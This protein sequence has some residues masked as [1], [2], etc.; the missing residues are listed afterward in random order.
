MSDPG[1]SIV[2]DTS[3][4]F[5]ARPGGYG[6]RAYGN[7]APSGPL[8]RW[9]LV[10]PDGRVTVYAGKVEYGQN[11]R[12]GL[13]VEVADELRVPLSSV[14][15]ILGDTD[16]TPW[17]MGTFGSQ[18]TARAGLQL[19]HAAATARETLIEMAA[20]RLDLPGEDLII[21]DGRI[22]SSAD[23]GRA[24]SY[25]DLL[26]GETLECPIDYD[27]PL[28]S[29]SGFTVMGSDVGRID[30]EARV[31]GRAVYSQDVIRP[32]MLFAGVLRA[33]K[34]GAQLID[35]DTSAAERMP[36]VERVVREGDLI[37]VLAEDDESAER[38]LSAVQS[39]WE[40][41]AEGSTIDVPRILAKTRR[42][43]VAVQEAG[44]VAGA[45][46]AAERV[47]EAT[48]YAP[49]ITPLPM[50]PRATVAEW[51][52]DRL[53]VW[54]GTQRPFGLR[55]E[56]SGLFRIP[57]TDVHVISMEI[58][59]GFGTKSWYPVAAEAAK[60]ARIA[61]RP[62]RVAY[63]RQEDAT[64][65]TYRP[66]ALIEI[67]S[68]FRSDGT[69]TAWQCDA[70]HAGP[71]AN[72]A[73]REAKTPYA[74]ENVAVNV[75][76]ANTLVRVGSYRTLGA[77]ANNFARE[78]HMDEIAAQLDIDPFEVR[79]RNLEEPR[80]R[81][82]L[83][84][85]ATHFGWTDKRPGIGLAVGEDVG[86]YVATCAEVTVTGRDIRVRR[87]VTA[88]DCGLTV[89]PEG[90]RN[91]VEGATVMGLGGALYEAA[92]LAGGV[93]LNTSLSR[94]Q[95]PR[96][97]DTPE[98]EV[99]LLGDPADPSTGAGEPGLVTIAPVLANAVFNATGQRIRELPLKRQ[100]R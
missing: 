78:S 61:G 84:A 32:G 76:C 87:V 72:I 26:T 38:A 30:A 4:G 14:E 36:G 52:G 62:V 55:T 99:L 9:L 48:Y 3:P 70:V 93:I 67:R 27:A 65:G 11:I 20:R 71:I 64:E 75:Y 25:S 60:L 80:Y 10:R 68:A 91:Q 74:I 18:S 100:L 13:A 82:V 63:T 17:D 45:F 47:L 94:Y 35:A 2:G 37:A 56:L 33:P 41:G 85:A 89:N 90:V 83:K 8:V 98:I 66:A 15:V 96:I 69:V 54:A 6:A 21:G 53:T 29:P 7:T 57:E 1:L 88:I 24:F 42:D 19:R 79:M 86:T 28:T 22:A 73:Q 46:R 40:G 58:G 23:P 95:V 39:T 49:H 16:L 5:P 43:P 97:T 50:E 44:D 34:F 77:A 12:T 92:E 51:D 81:R 59:G 31:T